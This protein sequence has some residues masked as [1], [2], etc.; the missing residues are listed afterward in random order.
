[1]GAYILFKNIT[2]DDANRVLNF[3]NEVY[4]NSNFGPSL[5]N[6]VG[7]CTTEFTKQ[8]TYLSD[9][10]CTRTNIY[11][12]WVMSRKE[13][14]SIDSFIDAIKNEIDEYNTCYKNL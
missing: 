6:S 13:Y 10:M 9:D 2:P 4:T 1:M 12:S 7:I 5:E 8:Y 14:T 11:T 3:L